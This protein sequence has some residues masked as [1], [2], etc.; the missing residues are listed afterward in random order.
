MVKPG[1]TGNPRF[2]ISARFAPLPPRRSRMPAAPSALPSPKVYTHFAIGL[3]PLSGW[4]RRRRPRLGPNPAETQ[5]NRDG[6]PRSDADGER[7]LE[8]R[9]IDIAARAD[10]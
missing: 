2:D 5:P 1:G 4:S 9:R 6:S 10:R 7:P 3:V 8:H